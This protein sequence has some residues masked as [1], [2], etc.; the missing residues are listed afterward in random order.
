MPP[1]CSKPESW[2]LNL[3]RAQLEREAEMRGQQW[4]LGRSHL[5]YAIQQELFRDTWEP[6]GQHSTIVTPLVRLR[7]R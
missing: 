1:L 7:T 2:W 6:R 5:S 3:D 4:K